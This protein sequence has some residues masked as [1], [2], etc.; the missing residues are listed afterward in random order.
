MVVA[1]YSVAGPRMR[2]GSTVPGRVKSKAERAKKSREMMGNKNLL[3]HRH[4]KE[5]LEKMRG[6]RGHHQNGNENYKN[7]WTPERKK[8]IGAIHAGKKQ[9][10]EQVR[11]RVLARKKTLEALGRTH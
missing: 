10:A 6:P 2:R 4:S 3:G 11:K 7:S 8:M 1:E 9:S 5:T